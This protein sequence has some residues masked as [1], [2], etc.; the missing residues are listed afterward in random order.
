MTWQRR[1]GGYA[2]LAESYTFLAESY[3]FLAESYTFLAE[4][5]TSFLV[6]AFD[7]SFAPPAVLGEFSSEECNGIQWHTGKL[8]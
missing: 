2:F 4:S 6:F 1:G 3:T 7:V 8:A 5:Y